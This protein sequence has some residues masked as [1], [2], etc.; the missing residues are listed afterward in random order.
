MRCRGAVARRQEVR[1][2]FI[3]RHVPRQTAQPTIAESAMCADAAP[4]R[5]DSADR[6]AA[7]RAAERRFRA[8]RMAGL[9]AFRPTY[10]QYSATMMR[11]SH[12][13]QRV[14]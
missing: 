6:A 1:H 12:L 8:A 14:G 3:S 2:V 13:A 7:F 9:A 4:C 11:P 5:D 10:P